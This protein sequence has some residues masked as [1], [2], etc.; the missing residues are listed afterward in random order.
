M[1]I[2]SQ[3]SKLMLN[4]LYLRGV[5]WHELLDE[6]LTGNFA[7]DS[8]DR[9]TV[10]TLKDSYEKPVVRGINGDSPSFTYKDEGATVLVFTTNCKQYEAKKDECLKTGEDEGALCMVSGQRCK[11]CREEIRKNPVGIPVSY[12]KDRLTSKHVIHME[13][14]YCTFECAFAGLKNKGRDDLLSRYRDAESM[15]RMIFSV[16]HPG[17]LL[18]KAPDWEAHEINQGTLTSEAFHNKHHCYIPI[19]NWFF[20]PCKQ[21][22]RQIIV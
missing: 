19:S 5:N 2:K 8:L 4:V 16:S 18:K 13:G 21:M 6:Y 7:E 20:L 10:V 17:K 11:W 1:E 9:S 22:Y 14:A 15:L 3:F 12:Y